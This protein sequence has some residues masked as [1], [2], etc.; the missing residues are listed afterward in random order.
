MSELIL[1]L[2]ERYVRRC[3]NMGYQR[4]RWGGPTC[5]DHRRKFY[6]TWFGLDRVRILLDEGMCWPCYE[7]Y[8]QDYK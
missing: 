4:C 7:E 8:L 5:R 6:V 3:M 2:W 1:F